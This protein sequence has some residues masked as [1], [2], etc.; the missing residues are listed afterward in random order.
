M[1]CKYF[2]PRLL[3]RARNRSRSSSER[4]G[5]GKSP[6]SKRAKIKS[7]PADQN[8]QTAAGFDFFQHWTRLARVFAGRN[9][10]C[11]C[12]DIEQV[13]RRA[14]ALGRRGLWRRR[15]QT[16]DTWRQ[17]RSL[18]SRRSKRSASARES[19]VLPL[20]VGPSTTTS[21]GSS[22]ATATVSER[23]NE[24]HASIELR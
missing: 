15:Y 1:R 17:N 24:W 8:R 3:A 10:V 4:C 14:S 12:N 2:E 18:R 16:R 22:C 9:V 7:G 21:S 23:S 20:A 5:P 11:R 19:A 13:M 6:S